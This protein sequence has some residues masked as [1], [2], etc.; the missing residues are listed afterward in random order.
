MYKRQLTITRSHDHTPTPPHPVIPSSCVA[1]LTDTAPVAGAGGGTS[2]TT[3][4]EG[5]ATAGE[6]MARAV[7][8]AGCGETVSLK[9][10]QQ[11]S[12][13]GG[14]HDVYCPACNFHRAAK[15]TAACTVPCAR[16]GCIGTRVL[17]RPP[18]GAA[19]DSY[20]RE[21]ESRRAAEVDATC[22]CCDRPGLVLSSKLVRE[23]DQLTGDYDP[24][25]VCGE[26]TDAA[27]DRC[28]QCGYGRL[29]RLRSSPCCRA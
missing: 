10:P 11:R 4:R 8:C 24:R 29:V 2:T 1:V 27:A 7:P 12:Q 3:A 19:R 13:R 6:W 23:F 14:A 17:K 25:F 28:L 9:R 22:V 5:C 18:Q 16:E 26:C 21:C 20:C 15:R